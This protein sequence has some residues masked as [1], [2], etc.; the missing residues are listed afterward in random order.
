MSVVSFGSVMTDHSPE[1]G[2]TS[3]PAKC[4][5]GNSGLLSQPCNRATVQGPVSGHAHAAARHIRNRPCPVTSRIRP[6]AS[7]HARFRWTAARLAPV[8][9]SAI[10]AETRG[11]SANVR[12]K[13]GG[14]LPDSALILVS[15]FADHASMLPR[16][17]IAVSQ[18]STIP[19]SQRTNL[20][21]GEPLARSPPPMARGAKMA[22]LPSRAATRPAVTAASSWSECWPRPA[23]LQR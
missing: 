15:A 4:S 17:R 14:V 23:R 18:A 20:S 12:R 22:P 7:I 21:R 8:S 9:A 10:G 2:P 16:F 1:V 19:L 5:S 13:A 11:H 3:L 6:R